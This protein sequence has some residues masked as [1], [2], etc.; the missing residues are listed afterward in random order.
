MSVD[1]SG[2]VTPATKFE[3]LYDFSNKVENSRL[4]EQRDDEIK[5]G[6]YNANSKFL[7]SYLDPKDHLTGTNYDP[8]IVKGYDDLL[9]Q[10]I[11]LA[12][13][14]ADTPSIMM[15]LGPGVSKMNQYST[16]AKLVNERI[17]QQ[18]QQIKPNTGYNLSALEQEAKKAAFYGEDGKLKDISTIDPDTDW[19]TKTVKDIPD[20]VTTDQGLDEFVTKS[21]QFSSIKNITAYN[22]LGGMSKVNKKITSADWLTPDMDKRGAV[23]GLV[24]KYQIAVDGGDP[25]THDFVDEKGNK[26]NAPVRLLD[27]GTFKSMMSSNPSVADYVRGLVKQHLGEYKSPDGKQID[28]NSPQATNVARAIL[29]DELKRRNR[30][31]IEDVEIN[32][33]PSPQQIRINL[34]YP[35][36]GS[37]S[38]NKTDTEINDHYK[39]VHDLVYGEKNRGFAAARVNALEADD[40][41][42]IIKKAKELAGDNT[43]SNADIKLMPNENGTVSLVLT[44]QKA[45]ELRRNALLG[46]LSYRSANNKNQVGVKENRAVI[47]NSKQ[48]G[49]MDASNFR[50]KYNY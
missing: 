25:I 29:Y 37:A 47:K 8:Q 7:Q 22:K 19:V 6:K 38:G 13:Q 39:R 12:S 14:G 44:D 40:Q 26:V 24:P 48:S 3:G 43:L 34:G 41:E 36:Y 9:Q 5:Q 50:S 11:Q 49:K 10:G 46:A 28:M 45:K 30:G 15:A 21:P 42:I 32:N 23:I 16:T 1:L 4:R 27:E 2:F 20:R 18:L 33:K 35:A 31:T 17:K